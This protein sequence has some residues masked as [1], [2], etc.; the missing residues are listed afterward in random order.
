MK[1]R[2]SRNGRH[3]RP[4]AARDAAAR[5]GDDRCD[6]RPTQEPVGQIVMGYDREREER[7]ALLERRDRRAGQAETGIRAL[8]TID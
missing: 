2:E 8:P 7:R 4:V 1:S 6:I 3:V 5:E